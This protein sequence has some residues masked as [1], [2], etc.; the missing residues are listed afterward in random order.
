MNKSIQKECTRE[1]IP[2]EGKNNY[3]S[4]ENFIEKMIKITEEKDVPEKN[5]SGEQKNNIER[6][7]LCRKR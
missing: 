7:T 3:I 4:K 1:N 6:G 5:S 2:I